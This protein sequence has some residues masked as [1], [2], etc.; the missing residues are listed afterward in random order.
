MFRIIRERGAGRC[1][2]MRMR[3]LDDAAAS[4]VQAVHLHLHQ[5]S[6]TPVKAYNLPLL[7]SNP[8]H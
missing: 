3:V 8:L 5:V 1:M 6:L 2:R 4:A 7:H